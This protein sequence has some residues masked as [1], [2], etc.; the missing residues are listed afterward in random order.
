MDPTRSSRGEIDE[1]E[2]G[3]LS[4]Y[5]IPAFAGPALGLR[6]LVILELLR[7]FTEN[8]CPLFLKTL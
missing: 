6:T 5:I 7:F 8:R 1:S 4:S 2:D 3:S